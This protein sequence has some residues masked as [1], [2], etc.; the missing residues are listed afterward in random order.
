M[1]LTIRKIKI[2]TKF[3]DYKVINTKRCTEHKVYGKKRKIPFSDLACL[4]LIKKYKL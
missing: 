2:N 1:L 4:S 3:E